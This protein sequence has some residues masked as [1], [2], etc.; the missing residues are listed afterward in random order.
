MYVHKY[1]DYKRYQICNRKYLKTLNSES[2][3]KTRQNLSI[4]NK[5]T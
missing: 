5:K 1:V 4:H 3:F 2:V